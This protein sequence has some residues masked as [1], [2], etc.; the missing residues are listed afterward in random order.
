MIIGHL[1]VLAQLRTLIL[2]S[3]L[4]AGGLNLNNYMW[5]AVA[6]VNCTGIMKP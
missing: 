6:I 1:S 3:Y 4:I 2:K 5:L